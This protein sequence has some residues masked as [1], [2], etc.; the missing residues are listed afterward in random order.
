P[1]AAP[2]DVV[3]S[4]STPDAGPGALSGAPGRGVCSERAPRADASPRVPH[5]GVRRSCAAQF[6]QLL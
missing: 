6:V 2:D 4:L 5:P 3:R 1:A